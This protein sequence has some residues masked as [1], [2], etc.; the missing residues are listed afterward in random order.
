MKGHKPTGGAVAQKIERVGAIQRQIT[1]ERQ[2]HHN[3]MANLSAQ[4]AAAVRIADP[5][6][7]AAKV[8][9]LRYDETEEH[10]RHKAKMAE[11]A[12]RA[13]EVWR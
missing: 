10:Q 3:K 13:R 1:R 11:L 8:L 6:L 12:R 9:K 7:C 5:A 4:R 2:R